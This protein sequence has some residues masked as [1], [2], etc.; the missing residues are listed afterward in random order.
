MTDLWGSISASAWRSTPC[1]AGRPATEAD[2]AAGSAV[3]YVPGE[4]TAA[5]MALPCCAIQALE[6]GS[7]QSVVIVQAEVAP[8]GTILGVRPLTGGNGICMVTEVRLL[9]AGF[10]P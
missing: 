6:D 10:E 7:E 9:P 4:S 3:F 8:E 5:P 2:V 1:I